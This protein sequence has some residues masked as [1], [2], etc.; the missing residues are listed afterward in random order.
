MAI[1]TKGQCRNKIPDS[2]IPTSYSIKNL[3]SFG[4][5]EYPCSYSIFEGL[6]KTESKVVPV[7]N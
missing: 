1:L 3:S 2:L 7:L 6:T 5:H 4:Y